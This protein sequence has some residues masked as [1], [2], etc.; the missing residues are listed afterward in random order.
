MSEN[1]TRLAQK[2]DFSKPVTED[3][4]AESSGED[5]PEEIP[6]DSAAASANLLWEAIATKIR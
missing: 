4:E 6:V 3:T 2:I 5:K 1:L